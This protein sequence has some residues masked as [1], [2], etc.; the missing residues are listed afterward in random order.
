MRVAEVRINAGLGKRV[1]I[2][3]AYVGKNSRW[4]VRIVRR[5][6]LRI[7]KARRATGD[8]VAALGPGPSHGV[9]YRDVD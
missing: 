1:L 5:T 8:T 6:K 9:A 2:N 7:Y 3:R 4:T